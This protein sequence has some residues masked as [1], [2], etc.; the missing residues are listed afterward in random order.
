[1]K[2]LRTKKVNNSNNSVSKKNIGPDPNQ[3]AGTLSV[4]Y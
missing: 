1:M 4:N 2:Q 3:M